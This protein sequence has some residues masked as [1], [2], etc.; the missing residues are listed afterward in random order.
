M[1]TTTDEPSDQDVAEWMLSRL[2]KTGELYQEDVAC[3]IRNSFGET[4]V[5]LNENGNLAIS[6]GVLKEFRRISGNCV[7]WERGERLWRRRNV[8]DTPSRMQE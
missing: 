5:H 7:V 6:R 1:S 4:F 8:G 3:R 2:K